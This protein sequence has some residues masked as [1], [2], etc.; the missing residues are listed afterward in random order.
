MGAPQLPE[1]FFAHGEHFAIDLPG[2]RALFTTR[3]GGVSNGPYE[4]LN[5]GWLTD[6]EPEAVERNRAGLQDAV[7][8][9]LSFVRQVHG[10]KLRM[11]TAAQLRPRGRTRASFLRPMGRSPGS[12]GTPWRP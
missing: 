11:V 10:V 1:P 12:P 5:L 6:D 4:S 8:R 7:G 9:P 2:S 3:R